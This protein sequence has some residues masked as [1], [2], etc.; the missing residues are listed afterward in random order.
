MYTI[1]K[2]IIASNKTI[3]EINESEMFIIYIS[4]IKNLSDYFNIH[5][6][7]VLILILC[8][9]YCFISILLTNNTHEGFT[10]KNKQIKF[11]NSSQ[12]CKLIN[13]IDYFKNMTGTDISARKFIK[14]KTNNQELL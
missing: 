13:D 12:A 1:I 2:K 11:L 7:L 5:M 14:G 9:F 4:F 10:S 8:I 6:K 3:N